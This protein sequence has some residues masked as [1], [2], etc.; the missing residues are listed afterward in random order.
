VAP[1]V[2]PSSP[3]EPVPI[4]PPLALEIAPALARSAGGLGPAL[5]GLVALRWRFAP[6]WS[7]TGFALAPIFSE[8]LK[9]QEGSARVSTFIFGGVGDVH[10]S[11]ARWE[12]RIGAGLGG[13]VSLMDGAASAPFKGVHDTVTAAAPMGHAAVRLALGHGWGLCLGAF[14]GATFPTVSIIFAQREAAHWGRP[15]AIG[16]LGIEAPLV[17]G[18][19][20]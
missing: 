19:P 11:G 5:D 14:A 4:P 12:L 7:I 15:F 8:R 17:A 2:E 18:T 13:V 3:E 9:G 10:V 6:A 16:T 20:Q 1:S